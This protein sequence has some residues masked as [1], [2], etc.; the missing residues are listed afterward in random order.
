MPRA[1]KQQRIFP[2]PDHQPEHDKQAY[3]EQ[4]RDGER[5]PVP[6]HLQQDEARTHSP[7]CVVPSHQE[8][9]VLWNEEHGLPVS[10]DYWDGSGC[11]YR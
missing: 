1:P 4:V 11:V 7:R 3:Y 2:E 6:E 5:V 10:R 8:W 9:S